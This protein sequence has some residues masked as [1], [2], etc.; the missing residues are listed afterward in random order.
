[1][2][3]TFLSFGA[4]LLAL[5]LWAQD[6]EMA[7]IQA[8]VDSI[9]NSLT[10]Q[11]GTINLANGVATVNVPPG[12]KYLDS[13]Q[14]KK[15]LVDYWGNPSKENMTLGFILPEKQGV[16]SDTGYVFNIEYNEVGYV[17]DNDA[18]DIDYDDLLKDIQKSSVEENKTRQEQGYEPIYLVGWASQPYYD[19]NKK[20]LHWA[21]ELRFGDENEVPNTLNYNVRVLGRKGILVMNAISIMPVL[22]KV[23]ADIPKIIDVVQFSDGYRY[24]DF[25][26]SVDEVA[27]W[28]LGSLVA[29]KVLAKVGFFALLLKF[30]KI[31]AVAVIAAIAGI[32]RWLSGRKEEPQEQEI[33]QTDEQ[34]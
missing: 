7:A 20:I 14:A 27:A 11:K 4:I 26:S 21:K 23:K 16:M 25:N 6:P 29:G 28:T 31:I 33:A 24:Q 8:L 19:K 3:K 10:Y 9:E 34:Q 5:N 15:V 1:M 30:W 22:D 12:F 32:R 2:K 13:E 17:K 18:N